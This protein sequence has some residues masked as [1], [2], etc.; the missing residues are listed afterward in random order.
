VCVCVVLIYVFG[1][2]W[3]VCVWGRVVF[4]GYMWGV[5]VCVCVCIQRT[6]VFAIE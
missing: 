5:C 2:V 3:C 1:E 6:E 4:M